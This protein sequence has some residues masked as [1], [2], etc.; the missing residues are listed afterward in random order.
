MLITGTG[1]LLL[2]LLNSVLD[3]TGQGY[4][5]NDSDNYREAA[6]LLYHNGMA[7]YYRPLLMAAITGLPYLLGGD[8]T[9]VYRFSLLVNVTCWIGTALLLYEL[10]K[11]YTSQKMAL[12]GAW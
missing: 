1:L 10:L 11:V 5:Y 7:H 6:S 2:L 4:I 3:I 8:D 9:D 12:V